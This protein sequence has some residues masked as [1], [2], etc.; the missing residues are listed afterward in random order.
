[1][2]TSYSLTFFAAPSGPFPPQQRQAGS[3]GAPDSPIRDDFPP[4]PEGGR[5]YVVAWRAWQKQSADGVLT[6]AEREVRAEL[7]ADLFDVPVHVARGLTLR[8][9]RHINTLDSDIRSI[10]VGAIADGF[11]SGA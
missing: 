4:T 7:Y 11:A 10:V 2:V 1:V 5:A 3:H 8:Q 9:L 6:R